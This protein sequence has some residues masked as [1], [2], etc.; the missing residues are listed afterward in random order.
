LT[1][2][3]RREEEDEGASPKKISRV[4]DEAFWLGNRLGGAFYAIDR[5]KDVLVRI[6]LGG[7]ASPE[8]KME[9]SEA[10]AKKAL[11]RIK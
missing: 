5:K 4:S 7:N 11:D 10:L 2:S 1:E 6:S 3:R 8:A 9:K